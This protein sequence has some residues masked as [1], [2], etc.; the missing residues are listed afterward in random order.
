MSFAGAGLSDMAVQI[1]PKLEPAAWCRHR[2]QSLG[3]FRI[4]AKTTD[5]LPWTRDSAMQLVHH[6][7]VILQ[8][9][10]ESAPDIDSL[11]SEN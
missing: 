10:D 7:E 8:A 3:A 5:S 9:I 2:K 11:Y 6:D 4:L 1:V